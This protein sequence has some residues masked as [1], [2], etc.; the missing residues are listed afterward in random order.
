M[1]EAGRPDVPTYESSS[2]W[3]GLLELPGG[4]LQTVSKAARVRKLRG[5][6]RQAV[7]Q[8]VDDRNLWGLLAD[9]SGL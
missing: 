8:V 1:E 5:L 4:Y 6:M 2:R 7:S 3:P 9:I